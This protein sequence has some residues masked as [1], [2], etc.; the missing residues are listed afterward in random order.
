MNLSKKSNLC[1]YL[2][3]REASSKPQTSL[4]PVTPIKSPRL[5][6]TR[7]E[8]FRKNTENASKKQIRNLLKSS[9]EYFSKPST[10]CAS[11]LPHIHLPK[12]PPSTKT[13]QNTRD[14]S[15]IFDQGKLHHHTPSTESQKLLSVISKLTSPSQNYPQ[16]I[17]GLREYTESFSEI[18]QQK[19][20][21]KTV[22]SKQ[23][24]FK[25]DIFKDI[26][27]EFY[28]LSRMELLQAESSEPILEF[29]QEINYTGDSE[30]G[31]P[32]GRADAIALLNWFQNIVKKLNSENSIDSEEKFRLTQGVYY[33]AYK[34]AVRQVTVHCVERGR[35][36][37]KIWKSYLALITQMGKYWVDRIEVDKAKYT[38]E[39]KENN[40]KHMKEIDGYA[41]L[42]PLLKDENNKMKSET[43][44]LRK[45]LHETRQKHKTE[46]DSWASI[47]EGQMNAVEEMGRLHNKNAK[48][49]DE[50]VLLND[51]ICGLK[52][53]YAEYLLKKQIVKVE[54]EAQAGYEMKSK[55]VQ[56]EMAKRFN[57]ATQTDTQVVVNENKALPPKKPE[58]SKKII[59]TRQHRQ[60]IPQMVYRCIFFVVILNRYSTKHSTINAQIG[61]TIDF[62]RMNIILLKNATQGFLSL[63]LLS[64]LKPTH[65]LLVPSKTASPKQLHFPAI[66]PGSVYNTA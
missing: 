35:V 34:E 48:L 2:K 44:I 4:T 27:P 62:M 43:E 65:R 64:V 18:L 9:I 63:V 36:L 30:L 29:N 16:S 39:L 28:Q 22:K 40:E 13:I 49:N 61:M 25:T 17:S 6:H 58:E 10:P 46:K 19:P 14:V 55:E 3:Q 15:Y 45:E 20:T 12:S 52:K 31:I 53:E 54:V 23:P 47:A 26:P 59:S 33:I 11:P 21:G 57:A 8:L 5:L 42:I 51:I 37:W 66:L 1:M 60:C 7:Q 56:C 41:K 32:A 24:L 38:E 50:I